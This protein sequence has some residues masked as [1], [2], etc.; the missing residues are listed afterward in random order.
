MADAAK[1][2]DVQRLLKLY[3]LP[4]KTSICHSFKGSTAAG[5]WGMTVRTYRGDYTSIGQFGWDGER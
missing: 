2:L 1:E 4:P 3:K 5:A